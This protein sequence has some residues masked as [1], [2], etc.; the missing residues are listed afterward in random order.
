[1][2]RAVDLPKD[3]AAGPADGD[4]RGRRGVPAGAVDGRSTRAAA[5]SERRQGHPPAFQCRPGRR[6]GRDRLRVATTLGAMF[7]DFFGPKVLKEPKKQWRVGQLD[8]FACRTPV[9]EPFKRRPTAQASGSSTSSRTRTSWSRFSTICT[10][11][12][13][14]PNWLAG[15]QKVQVPVPR[16]RLLHHRRELRRPDAAA[17]GAL[18]DQQGRRRLPRVDKRRSI[19]R[20]WASGII[21]RASCRCRKRICDL[22][23]RFA[24]EGGHSQSQIANPQFE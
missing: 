23:L 16:L 7:Q 15:E 1:M 22:R 8:D 18:R 6:L 9:Y 5:S 10:H 11:L 14:I 20:S 3:C 21:R 2:V 13:C 24:I 12:G 19:A 17:A 4:A